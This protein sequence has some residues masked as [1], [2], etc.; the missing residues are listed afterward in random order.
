MARICIN[1]GRKIG[2]FDNEPLVLNK[3]RVLCYN[4]Y[5]G[6]KDK[7]KKLYDVDSMEEFSL[8]KKEILDECNAQ[9]KK[10]VTKDVENAIDKIYNHPSLSELKKNAEKRNRSKD[11][12]LTTGYEFSGYRITKYNGIVSGQVVLGT[13]FLS[14]FSA[15]F[16]DFFGSESYK[17]ADKLE[18]AKNAAVERMVEK[19]IDAGGN[20]LIG[21]D[22]DYITFRGN[23]IGV[24]ANGTSVIVEKL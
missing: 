22:F 13:G 8:L 23:M 17:F 21:V 15:S 12:M 14:E 19:S 5:G 1:C 3:D 4:C 10:E 18:A 2:S 9:L 6:L 24:V 16:S 11:F 20:A 7:L